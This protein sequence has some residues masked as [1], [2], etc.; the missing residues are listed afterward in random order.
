[1]FEISFRD[2][3]GEILR[4]ERFFIEK[5]TLEF[6]DNFVVTRRFIMN[7]KIFTVRY[8]RRIA[9]EFIIGVENLDGN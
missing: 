1:M 7:G 8:K 5:E 9:N 4:I 6:Y 2:M 3:S